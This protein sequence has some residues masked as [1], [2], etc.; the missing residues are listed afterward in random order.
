[1]SQSTPS[2]TQIEATDTKAKPCP[3]PWR[4]DG[5]GYIWS[6]DNLMIADF[7]DDASYVARMRGAGAGM[8]EDGR[9]DANAEFI[10]RACNSHP[11]FLLALQAA[12]QC[13]ADFIEVYKRGASMVVF[14]EAVKSMRSDALAKVRA[15]LKVAAA[16]GDS[17]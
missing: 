2:T 6:A 7:D 10:V 13:M 1:M 12:E 16:T 15:A 9:Q 11:Q 3:T 4:Y 17:K 8:A 5:F 14:D